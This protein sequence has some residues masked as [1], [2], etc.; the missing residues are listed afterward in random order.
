VI[1]DEIERIINDPHLATIGGS[2]ARPRSIGV[3]S[4]IGSEQAAFIQKRLMDRIGEAAMVHHRIICGDSATVNGG[5][6]MCQMA[7]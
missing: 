7:A 4:L 5:A 2:D 6:K 3:I 1:V